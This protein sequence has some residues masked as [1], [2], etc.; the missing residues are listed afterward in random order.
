MVRAVA[1]LTDTDP[2]ELPA[3]YDD[4]DPEALDQ[5][6]GSAT[7]GDVQ[8]CFTYAGTEVYFSEAG[9]LEVC[10]VDN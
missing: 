9:D 1:V 5:L 3:L 4:V 6:V 7:D 2:V 8:I 10:T